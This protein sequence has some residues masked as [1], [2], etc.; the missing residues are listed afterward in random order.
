MTLTSQITYRKATVDD[1]DAVADLVI[2]LCSG[3]GEPYKAEDIYLSHQCAFQ[4]DTY[5]C[6]VAE[7]DGKIEATLAFF[8]APELRNHSVITAHEANWVSRKNGLGR[9][10]IKY[11]ENNL[12]CDRIDFGIA[13]PRLQQ[14]LQILGYTPVKTIMRKHL[15]E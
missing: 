4:D 8:C 3:L 9:G 7:M 14:L 2:E 5:H 15:K 6:F 12:D 1:I 11:V 10:L 13:N